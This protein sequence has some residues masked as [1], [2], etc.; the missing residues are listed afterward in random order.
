MFEDAPHD[1]F[2]IKQGEIVLKDN[3]HAL[4]SKHT[5]AE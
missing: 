2:V 5:H 4:L 1:I 3:P